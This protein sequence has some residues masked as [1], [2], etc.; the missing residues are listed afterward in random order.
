MW[1]LKADDFTT[2]NSGG[3]AT[4]QT[5]LAAAGQLPFVLADPTLSGS[6]AVLYPP[7]ATDGT[8]AGNPVQALLM[9][10][11]DGQ[12]NSLLCYGR[13]VALGTIPFTDSNGNSTN[14]HVAVVIGS[15]LVGSMTSC[16]VLSSAPAPYVSLLAVVDLTGAYA[17]GT[18]VACDPKATTGSPNCPKAIG[19]V[20]LPTGGTDVKLNGSVA[21]VATGTNVLLVNLEDPTH[22]TLA[23]QINGSFGN[24]LALADNSLLVGSSPNG[25]ASVNTALLGPAVIITDIAPAVAQTDITG[26]TKAPLTVT[27]TVQ[28]LPAPADSSTLELYRNGQFVSSFPA[29]G[30]TNGKFTAIIPVGVLLDT[31]PESV[32]MVLTKPDGSTQTIPLNIINPQTAA[33]AAQ[34]G[35]PPPPAAGGAFTSSTPTWAVAGQGDVPIVVNGPGAVGLTQVYV[36]TSSTQWI[37]LTAFPNSQASPPTLA[38]TIPAGLL[39]NPDFLQ[40]SPAPDESLSIIFLV[41]DSSLPQ[42][43]TNTAL[44]PLSVSPE[45]LFQAGGLITV[46]ANGLTA[47]TN[48]VI[49]RRNVPA[50][51]LPTTTLNETMLQAALP[52]NFVGS[53][54]D[55]FVAIL[56]ADGQSLSSPLPISSTFQSP[57]IS[58]IFNSGDVAVT[59]V[60]GNLVWNGGDQTL[61]LDGF[62]L[63]AGMTVSFNAHR[64]DKVTTFASVTE[65]DSLLASNLGMPPDPAQASLPSK[66]AKVKAPKGL[67][68][69]PNFSFVA[70]L[71]GLILG[72]KPIASLPDYFVPQEPYEIGLGAQARFKVTTLNN[73]ALFIFKVRNP[74]AGQFRPSPATGK[75]KIGD[76]STSAPASPT[77]GNNDGIDF[78]T[79]RSFTYAQAEH[80]P[81]NTDIHSFYIRGLKLSTNPDT[82]TKHGPVQISVGAASADL[83]IVKRPLGIT[84][85]NVEDIDDVVLNVAN[86]FGVPPHMLKAQVDIESRFDKRTYR[87]EPLTLDLKNLTGD[88]SVTTPGER[89]AASPYPNYV[90]GGGPR[91]DGTGVLSQTCTFTT[92]PNV[93]STACPTVSVKPDQ[94]L[95]SLGVEIMARQLLP[96]NAGGRSP[97]L[98]FAVSGTSQPRAINQEV[99]EQPIWT[100]SGGPQA[101]AMPSGPNQYSVVDYTQGTFR[102]GA[103]LGP[104]GVLVV[105]Y[106]AMA[107]APLAATTNSFTNFDLNTLH[108]FPKDIQYNKGG[109]SIAQFFLDNLANHPGGGFFANDSE[110]ALEF[111]Y[112]TSQKKPTTPLDTRL[113]HATA[114][115]FAAGSYGPIQVS[116]VDYEATSPKRGALTQVLDANLVPLYQV[117]QDW[118]LGLSVGAVIHRENLFGL[119][120]NGKI[121]TPICNPC[122]TEKW[123]EAW[124]TVFALY[125]RAGP[126]Y[127]VDYWLNLK[128][129]PL[130]VPGYILN[131]DFFKDEVIRKSRDYLAN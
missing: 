127:Q 2:S 117:T 66:K 61:E 27:Y 79:N 121:A 80:E 88:S 74:N 10:S 60:K 14:K 73:V 48:V 50:F 116:L 8:F 92:D 26:H 43:G 126:K 72:G 7:S 130:P 23:G 90:I 96:A 75:L 91:L 122:S 58:E 69:Y 54:S 86:R 115:F 46:S 109:I 32:D 21:L 78:N 24:W 85:K 47:G 131:Q 113:S 107:T 102:L 106:D 36:R 82:G 1:D 129:P 40:I 77:L 5:L 42:L 114:Q 124:S 119:Q 95:F 94:T 97:R 31:P 12:T 41:K 99:R 22:P 6:Q 71:N 93:T 55:L 57:N 105:S 13:A 19:F 118:N 83:L 64:G 70:K 125:N 101:V 108:R 25:T 49:G 76:L 38:T 3:A 45:D 20:Q 103:S 104:D 110:N 112:D 56:S 120:Q 9:T 63:A 128:K 37:A 28:Q 111:F 44:S 65:T 4:T 39:V 62:G 123:E 68:D 89:I 29:T 87:Y 98:T 35:P 59:D 11:A 67:T 33:E 51:T 100:R 30:T 84:P 52:P 15:G 81:S 16:P 17:Q 34:F 18:T 53:G